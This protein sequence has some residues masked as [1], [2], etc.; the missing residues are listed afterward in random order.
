MSSR[1]MNVK[2][3]ENVCPWTDVHNELEPCVLLSYLVQT[4]FSVFS[5]IYGYKRGSFFESTVVI[6]LATFSKSGAAHQFALYT[7]MEKSWFRVILV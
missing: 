1:E 5:H 7:K 4:V 2:K 6:S 3:G